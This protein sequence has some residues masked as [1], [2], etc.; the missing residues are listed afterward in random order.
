MIALQ[1]FIADVRRETDAALDRL[2]PTSQTEPTRLHSAIRWSVF[3]G[4]K[5]FR[6]AIVFASGLTF[7]ANWNALATA[8]AAFEMVHTYSLVHDDLPAMDDDDLRRGKAACHIEFGEAAAILAGD[9]LQT[10]AFEAISSDSNLSAETRTRIV[11]ILAAASGTPNGMVAGQQMDLDA[12]GRRPTIKEIESIH[13]QKT[14]ALITAAAAAGAVIAGA[15]EA[16]LAAVRKYAEKLG[17]LF[18][19]TDDILDVTET[20][21]TLGKTAGKDYAAEKATYPGYLGLEETRARAGAVAEEA[22]E[23]L[24]A[25]ERDT[26]LL[27]DLVGLIRSRIT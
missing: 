8:A 21:A 10:L 7:G 16:D 22:R 26:D 9:C 3:A 25:L 20:T 15:H 12:E 1:Q 27:L 19:I 6:P 4:G 17:L 5:R 14:G 18:Q 13:A 23:A 2:I 11:S 24:S